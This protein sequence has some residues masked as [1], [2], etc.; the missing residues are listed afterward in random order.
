MTNSPKAFVLLSGG[1]DSAVCLKIA[2]SDYED[3]EAIHYNYGQQTF[4]REQE[5][6]RQQAQN[7]DIPLHVIDYRDVFGN[8]AEGTIQDQEY[9]SE[10]VS[11]Q[12]HSVGYVPQRNLHL[13]VSGAAVAEHNT[14]VGRDIVLYIGAQQN[15]AADYPDCRP[16]FMTAAE[17]A[18]NKST[19]QHGVTVNAPIIDSPKTEVIKRG[20]ELG[21]D[22]SLTF[23]CYN[24]IEGQPCG[25]CP[26]CLERK[27]AFEEAG[28]EDPVMTL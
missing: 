15:D 10:T 3:V 6:A 7:H 16:E 8:F 17:Q 11:E 13:L 4:H 12:G 1:I 5:N 19:K 2:L 28:L 22:W 27:E 23:S 9:D 25:E 14:E 24:D 18:I 20:Q 21:V 26:A